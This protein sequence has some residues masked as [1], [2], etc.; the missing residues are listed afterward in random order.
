ML[1]LRRIDR[2]MPKKEEDLEKG[3]SKNNQD[4]FTVLKHNAVGSLKSV[5]ATIQSI[6]ALQASSGVARYD[7]FWCMLYVFCLLGAVGLY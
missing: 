7:E 3:G 2:E 1:R 4:R 5:Q 6:Q